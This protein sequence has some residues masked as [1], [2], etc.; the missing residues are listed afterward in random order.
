[1]RIMG[2]Y[3]RYFEGEEVEEEKVEEEKP[4]PTS[5]P[6]TFTQEEVNKIA[7]EERRKAQKANEK[8][9]KQLEDLKKNA[10]LTEEQKTQLEERIET[11]KNEYLTKEELARKEA[12][13][14]KNKTKLE[15]DAKTK[16]AE[17]WKKMYEETTVDTGLWAA[18]SSDPDIFSPQQ[19]VDL[20]KPKTRLVEE[21][22][23]DSGQPTGRYTTKVRF[24]GKD[25][26]GNTITLDLTPTDVVKQMKEMPEVYGNQFRNNATGGVGGNNVQTRTNNSNVPPTDPAA[27]RE[28]RKKNLK[29][30]KG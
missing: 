11:I 29:F 1:M 9:V 14:D 24:A 10:T 20:L 17:K 28:W 2:N 30:I 22:E 16:E 4:V 5:T 25:K 13:K 15:L 12:A 8:T 19:I 3:N 23:E 27:Y 18:A 21:L 26:D 6:K 7:A